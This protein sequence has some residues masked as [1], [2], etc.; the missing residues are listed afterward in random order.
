V[1][2]RLRELGYRV[3]GFDAVVHS[4]VAVGSGLSS[5]AAFEVLMGALANWLFNDG[6]LPAD[7]LAKT[8]QYAENRYFGKPCGLMDQLTSAT[9]GASYID[10]ADP[11]I[12]RI[13]SVP[14]DPDASGYTLCVVQ[15]GGNH[16]DLTADYASIPSEMREVARSLGEPDCRELTR[17]RLMAEARRVRSAAG[18]RAFLRA[19]HFVDENERVLGQ[20]RSL[21]AGDFAT[22]LELVR[23][24]GNSS[25]MLLQNCWAPSQVRDQGL[26]LALAFTGDFLRGAGGGAC[27]VHGGGFAGTIQAYLPGGSLSRYVL[28]M[29]SLFGPGCVLPLS[30]RPHGAVSLDM[31]GLHMG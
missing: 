26:A 24:S 15:T 22:F 29:E 28:E 5:S 25:A 7:V 6:T 1:L 2:A 4:D 21:R 17:E 27:R 10:F 31:S 23:D 20:V 11:S 13:E 19:L 18:D 9:G 30:V 8:G 14:L 3:G 16:A 12:P